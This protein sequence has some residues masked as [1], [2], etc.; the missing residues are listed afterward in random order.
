MSQKL[1][2][3]NWQFCPSDKQTASLKS[4]AVALE[5]I[6]VGLVKRNLLWLLV[7]FAWTTPDG[8]IQIRG[9][10]GRDHFAAVCP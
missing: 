5:H 2:R 9:K 7:F 8:T 4:N 1:A 6:V 3:D 10:S